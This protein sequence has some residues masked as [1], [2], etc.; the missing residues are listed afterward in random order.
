MG[1]LPEA[2]PPDEFD[3]YTIVILVKRPD[4]PVL[5]E[6]ELELNQ[7]QHLGHFASLKKQGSLLAC[8]PVDETPDPAWRGICIYRAGL[9]DARLLA[10]SDPAVKRGRFKVVAFSWVTG[11]GSLEPR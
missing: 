11:K 4:A 10:E 6:E 2:E 1:E 8:G 3:Q 9:E 5:S 7:R